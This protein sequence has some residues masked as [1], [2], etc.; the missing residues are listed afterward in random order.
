MPY[1]A[2][3]RCAAW[4][5]AAIAERIVHEVGAVVYVPKVRLRLTK[6]RRPATG[7]LFATYILVDLDTVFAWQ[8][9]KRTPGVT[10]VVMSGEKPA[11]CPEFE[12]LKLKAAEVDGVVRLASTI[13]PSRYRPSMGEKVRIRFGPLD[14]REGRYAGPRRN[15]AQVLVTLLGRQVLVLV[16]ADA[17]EAKAG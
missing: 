3:A 14:G 13:V 12:I 7:A 16:A 1:W 11:R 4:R 2:A 17:I 10:G 5:E 15:L 9:I 8:A 6:S